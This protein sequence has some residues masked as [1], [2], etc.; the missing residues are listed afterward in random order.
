M[1]RSLVAAA[2]ISASPSDKTEK[3]QLTFKV[4]PSLRNRDFMG[5]GH[6]FT[7]VTTEVSAVV[8][9]LTNTVAL[10]ITSIS[11]V[12]VGSCSHFN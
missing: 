2:G 1:S 6:R 8:A 10:I 5:F 3:K 4:L 12:V 7:H 11:V 9:I